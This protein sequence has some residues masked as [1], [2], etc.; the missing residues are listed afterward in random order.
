MNTSRNSIEEM[1]WQG[2]DALMDLLEDNLIKFAEQTDTS[3]MDMRKYIDAE[4]N[5]IM[6]KVWAVKIRRADV[7][8]REMSR[9]VRLP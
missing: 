2:I 5:T 3:P 7:Y 9:D 4:L 1:G 6:E 8:M